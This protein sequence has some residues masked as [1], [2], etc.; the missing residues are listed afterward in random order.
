MSTRRNARS[1]A[2]PSG[3]E[4]S[5]TEKLV[6]MQENINQKKAEAERARQATIEAER[7]AREQELAIAEEE[8]RLVEELAQAQKE[9]EEAAKKREEEAA[10]AAAAEEEKKAEAKRKTAEGRKRKVAGPVDT[11]GKGRARATDDNEGGDG[12]EDTGM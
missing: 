2:P 9:E 6:R 8:R 1:T 7:V 4:E 3:G 5:A 10:A 11:K 12:D